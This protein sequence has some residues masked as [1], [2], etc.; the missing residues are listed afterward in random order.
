M[1][2]ILNKIQSFY[3]QGIK[4]LNDTNFNLNFDYLDLLEIC[5]AGTSK[6]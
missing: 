1:R 2:S 5:F 6:P 4:E 3:L